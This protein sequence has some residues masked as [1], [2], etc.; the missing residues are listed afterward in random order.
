MRPTHRSGPCIRARGLI[1]ARP[2]VIRTTRSIGPT[3]AIMIAPP[4]LREMS[5]QRSSLT[6]TDVRPPYGLFASKLQRPGDTLPVPPPTS[7][8]ARALAQSHVAA[9]GNTQPA[10]LLFGVVRLHRPGHTTGDRIDVS[11]LKSSLT[12]RCSFVTL[13]LVRPDSEIDTRLP[14]RRGTC[15]YRPTNANTAVR[16][17]TPS[18]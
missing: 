9:P 4:R 7:L 8:P 3:F 11:S 1:N 18:R 6:E 17:S 5:T 2:T 10:Q 12:A 13:I 16:Q 14:Q 15:G